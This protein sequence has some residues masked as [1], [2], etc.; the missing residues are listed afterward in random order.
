MPTTM[1]DTIYDKPLK[2]IEPFVFDQKVARV[3]EDMISRSVP[4][5]RKVLHYLPQILEGHLDSQKPLYDLGC[6][7]GDSLLV[8]KQT[9][10]DGSPPL[11]GVDCSEAMLEKAQKRMEDYH[12]TSDIIFEKADINEYPLQPCSAVLLNYTL[13]FL[14]PE[15]RLAL[16]ERIYD[17]LIPNGVLLLSEKLHFDNPL[18]QQKLQAVHHQFKSDQGYSQLA[19]SQKRNALENVLV[20]DTLATHYQR[21]E[22]AGFTSYT[23]WYQELNFCSILAI[24]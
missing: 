12:G 18:L 17:S 13:Q 8:L 19:I 20:T 7:L 2:K 15:Q 22:K 24:K 6:S 9:L 16:L 1:R 10:G 11:I 21:L 4:G 5:Y 3:F 14:G 23:C